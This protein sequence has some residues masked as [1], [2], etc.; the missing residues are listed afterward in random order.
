MLRGLHRLESKTRNLP[1]FK[2]PGEQSREASW[3][4]RIRARLWPQ[5]I[6]SWASDQQLFPSR[7]IEAS[8]FRLLPEQ[9]TRSPV[10]VAWR[11]TSA[12]CAC[13]WQSHP[14]NGCMHAWM[15]PCMHG[16]LMH[17]SANAVR[18]VH[19]P[20]WNWRV[21]KYTFCKYLF[22]KKNHYLAWFNRFIGWKKCRQLR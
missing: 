11:G 14:I 20:D 18:I 22:S 10:A 16:Q 15:S 7:H 21:Q 5:T 6:D 4:R 9:R 2:P 17:A 12:R 3:Q 13:V 19:V 8:A 1:P